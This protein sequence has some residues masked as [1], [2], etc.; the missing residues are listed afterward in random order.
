MNRLSH[1]CRQTPILMLTFICMNKKND[2]PITNILNQD[3]KEDDVLTAIQQ[4]GFPLQTQVASKLMKKF[5][6]Q[7]EWAY[8]DES[9]EELRTIDILAYK[10]FWTQTPRHPYVR[11]NLKLLIECKKSNQPYVFFLM[12]NQQQNVWDFP[13]I[14][15]L[16]QDK[17][18]IKSDDT[19]STLTT[20]IT[21]CLGVDKTS[22]SIGRE[23]SAYFSRCRRDGKNGFNLSDDL[24]KECVLP[25][26]KAIHHI[27]TADAPV[28]TAVY[29]DLNII[30]PIVVIDAPMVTAEVRDGE[31]VKMSMCPWVRVIRR[32]HDKNEGKYD[33]DKIVALDVVHKDYLDAYIDDQLLPFAEELAGKAL[34]HHKMLASGKGFCTGLENKNWTFTESDLRSI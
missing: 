11:P 13:I 33:R 31:G 16:K 22:F 34:K 10:R 6:V 9:S 20:K 17:I 29:F 26:S 3:L 24:F 28:T 19:R 21:H 27:R 30:I 12:A 4:S 25:L 32:E 15:G 5:G 8:I 18:T 7:E 1:L 2:N 14:T 23:Y